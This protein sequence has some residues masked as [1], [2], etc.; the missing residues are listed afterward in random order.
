MTDRWQRRA[1]RYRRRAEAAEAL[2]E[3]KARDL[4]YANEDLNL[5]AR[6]LEQ[7]VVERT[8]ALEAARDQALA[9]S[10]AKSTFL[11]NM[12]H[13]LRTPLNAITGYAELLTEEAEERGL[14]SFVDD[15]GT[16]RAAALQLLRLVDEV[17][18][19]SRIEAGRLDLDLRPIDVCRLVE[20]SVEVVA[21]RIRPGVLLVHRVPDGLPRAHADP[22]RL[23]QCLLNLLSNAAKFT[24]AGRIVVEARC[25]DAGIEIQVVDTG[26]GMTAEEG[27][28]LFT[29]F[30][31]ANDGIRGVYGGTGLGLALTRKLMERMDGWATLLQTGP[32]GSTFAL[33]VPVA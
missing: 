18:D 12:S 24:H 23:Q 10:R 19:L 9:A 16:V 29:T 5:L 33:G 20:S 31:Q 22:F 13:E 6:D 25:S 7:R 32:T 26:I 14:P 3:D 27:S 8:E 21:P 30:S 2:L 17:L 15:L 28:R 11:A 4:Y 1:E